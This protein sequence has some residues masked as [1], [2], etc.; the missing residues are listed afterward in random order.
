MAT[1]QYDLLLIPRL[2]LLKQYG[3][4]PLQM[5]AEDYEQQE[6][7]IDVSVPDDLEIRLS[8][9]CKPLS[10]W[11]DSARSWGAEDGNRIDV[12]YSDGHLREMSV[13]IDLRQRIAPFLQQILEL[14]SSLDCVFCSYGGEVFEPD[15]EVAVR[16]IARSPAFRFVVDPQQFLDGMTAE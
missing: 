15:R 13:R 2:K 1:W 4:I 16:N 11:S 6:W 8:D 12:C 14:A 5:R 10:S 7:W 9:I 3:S